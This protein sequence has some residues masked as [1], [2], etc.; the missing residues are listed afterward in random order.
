MDSSFE[1]EEED[2]VAAFDFNFPE[3]LKCEDG[4][5]GRG[6]G[7]AADVS[8]RNYFTNSIADFPYNLPATARG[9]WED[10]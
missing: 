5:F 3:G 4:E 7:H 1:L 10:C 2:S 8:V 6:E 9:L